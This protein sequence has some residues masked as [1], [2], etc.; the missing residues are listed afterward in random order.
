[1]PIRLKSLKEVAEKASTLEA[2][3]FG[4]AELLDEVNAVRR[5]GRALSLFDLVREEPPVLRVRFAGGETADAFGA[6]LAEYLS[7]EA[8]VPA[9]GWTRQRERFLSQAWFPLRQNAD[10][11]HLRSLIERETPPAFRAHNVFIDE[12]SL[13]RA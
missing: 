11:P 4:L 13:V 3:G 5:A 9:P 8:A 6:A 12:N 7:E 2:W 1:M 10:L